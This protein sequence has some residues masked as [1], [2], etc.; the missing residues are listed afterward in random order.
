MKKK[1]VP[2]NKTCEVLDVQVVADVLMKS[3]FL[4]NHF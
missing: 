4:L 1:I 2:V 3:A